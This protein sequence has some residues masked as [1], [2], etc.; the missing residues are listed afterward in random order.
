MYNTSIRRKLTNRLVICQDN[1]K[2]IV[3]EHCMDQGVLRLVVVS[4]YR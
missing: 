4:P 3:F 1:P 2:V